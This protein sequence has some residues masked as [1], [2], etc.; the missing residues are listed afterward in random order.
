M[1]KIRLVNEVVELEWQAFQ[2]VHNEGGRASCQDNRETFDI[3]RKSQYLPWNEEMLIRYK[4]DFIAALKQGRNL[5]TEKYAR[6]M[7]SNAK[8]EF[9]LIKDQLPPVSEACRALIE[10]VVAIQ[11]KWM[12]EF[13]AKYPYLA[14]QGRAIHTAEDTEYNTSYETYL[15][16]ELSTYSPAMLVLY[17]N[18][19]DDL[20]NKGCNLSA[21]IMKFTTAFYGYP[22]LEAAENKQKYTAA[23]RE[24]TDRILSNLP[25]FQRIA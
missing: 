12:E 6:M 9:A 13:A 17:A 1:D 2:E 4:A 18:F 10:A 20:R 16:G 19:V 3:M 23:A 22:S 11:V 7:E 15:R 5:V 24:M 25:D 21:L 8:E 14:G